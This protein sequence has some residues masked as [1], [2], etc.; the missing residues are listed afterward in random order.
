MDFYKHKKR[1]HFDFQRFMFDNYTVYT[2][3]I[4]KLSV[5]ISIKN[6][7]DFAL[8]V[9]CDHC[10][11]STVIQTT[12][13]GRLLLRAGRASTRSCISIMVALTNWLR[14]SRTGACLP[15][16]RRRYVVVTLTKVCQ[17]TFVVS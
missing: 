9:R 6:V 1:I 3:D 16:I 10:G 12:Q 11:C 14:Y 5:E 2:V 4:R 7:V 17:P 15:P 8:Q 13:R